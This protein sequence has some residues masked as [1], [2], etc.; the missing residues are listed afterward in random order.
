[1]TQNP[2]EATAPGVEC[3]PA[4]AASQPP[5]GRLFWF[6]PA[7]VLP[8]RGPDGRPVLLVTGTG[9]GGFLQLGVRLGPDDAAVA[10]L[11][12][13][14]PAGPAGGAAM[15]GPAPVRA[16]AVEVALVAGDGAVS[17]LTRVV[18]NSEFPCA[19]VVAVPLGPRELRAVVAAVEGRAGVLLVRYTGLDWQP[20]AL[21]AA[22]GPTVTSSRTSRT[23]STSSTT[24]TG[25]SGSTERTVLTDVSTAQTDVPAPGLPAPGP[26][27]GLPA[28]PPTVETDVAGW[29]ADG[30]GSRHVVG[31]RPT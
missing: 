11:P 31:V 22:H 28:L 19:A 30:Q 24:S 3:I 20:W 10:A 7:G 12:R 13:Q 8:E 23:S 25:R 5:G 2:Y 4:P 29:F 1:M 27:T 21:A 9:H 18:P 16:D 14:L 17:V 15:V 6:L 26:A